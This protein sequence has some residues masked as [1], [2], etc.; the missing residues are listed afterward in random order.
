MARFLFTY[1]GSDMPH[2]PERKTPNWPQLP[3]GSRVLEW[4]GAEGLPGGEPQSPVIPP[5]AHSARSGRETFT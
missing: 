5:P 3:R 1:H 4:R 2:D